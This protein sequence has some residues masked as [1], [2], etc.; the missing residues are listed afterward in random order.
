MSRSKESCLEIFKGQLGVVVDF[1]KFSVAQEA[2]FFEFSTNQSQRKRSSVDRDICLLEQEWNP[3]DVVL[4]SVRNQNSLDAVD[5]VHDVRVIRND[6]VD[7]KQV[8]FWEFNPSI[9]DDNLILVFNS[10][11]V[12]PDFSQTTDGKNANFFRFKSIGHIRTP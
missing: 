10:V 12:F 9:D 4:V 11:S 6:I 2:V 5:I 1:V 8:I 3:T 7:T